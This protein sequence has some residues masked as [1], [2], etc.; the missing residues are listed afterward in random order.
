MATIVDNEVAVSIND[1]TSTEGDHSAHYRGALVSG[2]PSGHFNPLT[3]GPDGN[4]YT[5]VGTGAGYNT[6]Q[7][8]DGS[9]G[10]F[11]DTFIKNDNADHPINGV[12]D[13][14]F[15]ENYVYVASAYTHE[16][17]RY[18]AITGA[19]VDVFVLAGAGGI[20]HPDG[21]FFGPDSN[22]DGVAE[23][24]V[25]GWTSHNIVRYDGATGQPL[26]TF[27]TPGSGGLSYPFAMAQ[28]GTELFVTSAGTN[29]I[30]KY[31]VNTGAY[32][33]VAASGNGLDYPRG[34]TFGSDNLMYV[35]SGN[36]DR[37]MRF[38]AT[39]AFVDDYVPAGAGGMD[40]P[41][42]L[43]FRDGDLY[44]TTTGNNEIM[45]FGAAS[46]AV[47]TVSLSQAS[48][49]TITI[50][51]TTLGGT[52]T[53]G[54]DFSTTTGTIVFNPGVTS[55]TVFVPVLDDTMSEGN[56]T[57]LVNLSNAVGATITDGQGVGTILDNDVAPTKFYVVND[58][59]T[60]RTYEYDATG[61]SIEDYSLNSG[62]YLAA[63]SRQQ[64][65]GRYDLGSR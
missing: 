56:E 16:V 53:A 11:L 3:F 46:E 4:I 28:R 39:G 45:R 61:G 6:V 62:N 15:R 63:R 8:F 47:F 59:S 19:F 17:L 10:A 26:G 42:A 52:A 5:A 51:F 20:A 64:R 43:R 24:Y 32:L 1:T 54:S 60:N 58:A 14:I 41:R 35:S 30:L 36:N 21:M 50:D 57:F 7:R 25:T 34:I 29:R 33:G 18:D 13:I 2:A 37:I 27:V 48:N 31:N 49:S 40:N 38:A 44:V 55:K 12:R 22:N 23:L 65:D 9:S